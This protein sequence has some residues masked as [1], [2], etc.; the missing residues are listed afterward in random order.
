MLLKCEGTTPARLLRASIVRTLYR[1][2]Y[3][4]QFSSMT[5]EQS[6]E[7]QAGQGSQALRYTRLRQGMG[8]G[9]QLKHF[10]TALIS[11]VQRLDTLC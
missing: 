3:Q 2:Q 10:Q 11:C 6:I 7:M 5:K 1:L 8:S 4:L 9:P